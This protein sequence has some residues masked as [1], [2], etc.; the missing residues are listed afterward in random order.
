VQPSADNDAAGLAEALQYTASAT[1]T[2]R[3]L[4]LYIDAGS[5]AKSVVVGLYADGG[6]KPGAL[7]TQGTITSPQAAA[8]NTVS[9]SAAQVSAGT[10]YWLALLGVGG[11]VNFRDVASGA[12]PT[13]NSAQA[14]L[15]GLPSTW[16]SGANWANSPASFYA[17]VSPAGSIFSLTAVPA[18]VDSNDAR[19]VE[20]GVKFRSDAATTVAGVRFY[21]S[22]DNTGAHTGSLWTASGTR[23]ATVTF[24]SESASGWQTALFATPV[25]IAANTTYIVSYHTAVGHYSDS[26]EFFANNGV[27]SGSLYALSNSA[28]GGNGVYAYGAGGFPNQTYK[29]TNY[30]VDVV[31]A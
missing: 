19:A 12:G 8:W 28:A 11:R 27:D 9:V 18:T 15:S 22:A 6:G 1:G 25:A 29:S 13:Q 24:A 26:S 7:L 20:L 17:G 30:W 10:K 21:K 23:L 16:G 2:A 14:N 31:T 4:S 5:A 3:T